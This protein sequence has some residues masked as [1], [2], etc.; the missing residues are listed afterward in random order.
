MGNMLSR[1]E[2]VSIL[3]GLFSAKPYGMSRKGLAMVDRVVRYL[4]STL[5]A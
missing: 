4:N 2:A 3:K 1:S 5:T